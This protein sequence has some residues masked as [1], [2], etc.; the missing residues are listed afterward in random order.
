MIYLFSGFFLRAISSILEKDG[1]VL[2]LTL[3]M[4]IWADFLIG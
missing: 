4:K 3:G 2:N 1:G